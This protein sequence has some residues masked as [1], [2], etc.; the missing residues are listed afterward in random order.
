MRLPVSSQCVAGLW[1]A[2]WLTAGVNA[3]D[4]VLSTP[5]TTVINLPTSAP[6][7]NSRIAATIEV[8]P[9]APRDLGVGAWLQDRHGRWWQR[10]APAPLR[11]G[12]NRVVLDV[13]AA[14][15]LTDAGAG[16]NPAAATSVTRGGLFLWSAAG[17]SPTSTVRITGLRSIAIDG[18]QRAG[19]P[20]LS[21]VVCDP[22]LRLSGQRWEVAVLPRPFPQQPSDPDE[23]AL[24]LLITGPDGGVRR[25]P[26][27]HDQ[28][29]RGSDRGDREEVV[30]DGAPRFR[31]RW[32]SWQPGLYR[33]RLEGRWRG[34]AVVQADLPS[35]TVEGAPSDPIV[36]RDQR[37]PRFLSLNGAFWWPIGV[38][39]RSVNDTRSHENL[40]TRLTPPRG[41]LAYADYF[42]RYAAAGVDTVE[43]VLSS[44]N[45]A[46]EWNPQWQGYGGLGRYHEGHA[47]QLDRILDAAAAHGIRVLLVLN[48]HGQASTWVD[49]EWQHN[50][51]NRVNGGPCLRVEDVLNDGTARRWQANLRRY[52]VARYAD[53]PALLG[54]KLWSECDFLTS[55]SG[56]FSDGAEVAA[57][58]E[59]ASAHLA[60][61]DTYGHLVTS[62]WSQDWRR[63]HPQ[64]AALD[65]LGLLT[66]DAY[67][68]EPGD[69]LCDLLASGLTAR[70]LARFRKP[71]LVSEYGGKS[72]GE[73]ISALP[74]QLASA[75]FCGLVTGYAGAPLCWWYEWIDQG[76]RYGSYQAI[77]GFLAG[78]DLRDPRAISIGLNSATEGL[79]IRGWSRPGRMLGYVLERSWQTWGTPPPLRAGVIIAIGQE[80]AAG[81]MDLAWWDCD[82]GRELS[83]TVMQHPGGALSLSAP[84][85]RG[86]LAWKLSRP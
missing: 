18:A 41:S 25:I 35:V 11:P 47:W 76:E 43:I 77:R 78:E 75:P 52:L 33:L 36:R 27:F 37:D 74:A 42:A 82:S 61:L 83:R 71:V 10:T 53:H 45:L 60:A 65:G 68:I 28:P 72:S 81:R 26:G 80:V 29:M 14:A 58:H 2:L 1:L 21:D 64:V 79:W 13:G 50:P 34:G 63:V 49:S 24:T 85:F 7:G 44:W 56:K 5:L 15:P 38:N 20:V 62:H 3:E 19:D 16:W 73:P 9:G 4:I 59:Q 57:W 31:A 40:G 69:Q 84:D 70:S 23:F 6:L 66:I 55:R 17:Q 22:S 86:H 12:V 67:R 32:R 46:L 39:L 8:P 48:N 54:W 51:L 30:A